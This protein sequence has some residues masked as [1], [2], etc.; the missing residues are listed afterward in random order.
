[1]RDI[2][3]AC[4][5]YAKNRAAEN[6]NIPPKP[7][8]IAVVGAGAAGLSCALNLA[9]KKFQVTVFDKEGG[10]GGSLRTH[11]LFEQF[12]ADFTLQFSA[13]SAEFRFG[14]EIKSLDELSEFDAVYVATGKGG[15]SFGLLQ[16]LHPGLLSTSN[17][18]VYMGGGLAGFDLME[19]IA[20]GI[21]A[22]KTIEVFLQTGRVPETYSTYDRKKC[23]RY[24]KHEGEQK[25]PRIIA[26]S[27][28]GY[29][30]Q[31]AMDEASRCFKCDCDYCE[32]SCEMLKYYRKKPQKIGMEVY[33]DSIANS[34]V[35]TRTVT[36]ETYSCNLCGKCKSVCPESVDIGALLQFSRTD[37]MNAGKDIPAYHDFWLRELDFYGGEG[38]FASAP[39]GKNTC[40]YAFFPGCQL[41]AFTPGH[42]IKS[43]EYLHNK[44][45][46][47]LILGCCGAPAYWAGDE[48]RL[49]ENADRIKKSW[50]GM[51][52]PALVFACASCEGIFEQFM[53]EIKRVSLY[54]LLAADEAVTPARVYQD[55]AVFDPCAARDD[56]E[57]Q[58]SVRTLAERAGVKLEELKEKNRCCGYGGHIRLANPGLYEEIT[59]NRAGACDKPYIV[60][61]ANC[62]DVFNHREKDCAHI[63]DMVFDA[64][65]KSEIPSLKQKRINSLE[66]KK[67]LMNDH[68]NLNFEPEAHEW[69]A[70]TLIIS[71]ELLEQL[72]SKLITEDDLKEAVWLAE[73]TGDK[74]VDES[75]GMSQSS[76]EKSA[77]TYWVQ[78]KAVAPETYEIHSAY[79]HRMHINKEE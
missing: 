10:W 24:L 2:E 48:K 16:S 18:K 14:K 75:D 34:L 1:M 64:E 67:T 15:E 41:G 21:D 27:P 13:V 22:S 26:A 29:S 8:R 74:F 12:D 70:L 73:R 69:D 68:W 56:A 62:R 63:L 44:Y 43:F 4:I 7:Q 23:D 32:A 66:V 49:K 65:A 31:E 30:E 20:Q 6:Y 3:A 76:M 46:T 37:R 60:Y 58:K 36:R 45:D 33:T 59:T 39:N 55:A 72:D 52:K 19:C 40:E 17:P 11:P 47:G 79:S 5:K 9:Q 25:K 78:Y 50:E 77:L 42:V 51:G 54:E 61:C 57:M 53:P 38:F 28:D 71:D 35:S